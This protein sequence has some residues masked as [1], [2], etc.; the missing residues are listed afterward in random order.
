MAD[1]PVVHI[2]WR[3]DWQL[4]HSTDP[5][6][7]SDENGESIDLFA[8]PSRN[9]GVVVYNIYYSDADTKEVAKS[10]PAPDVLQPEVRYGELIKT[11]RELSPQADEITVWI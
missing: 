5:D 3:K 9:M 1:Q 4:V 11:V 8:I 2:Y 6:H 7:K 10:E